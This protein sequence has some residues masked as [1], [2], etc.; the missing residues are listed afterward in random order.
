[1][2]NFDT[3][4]CVRCESRNVALIGP[5]PPN[6]LIKKYAKI[7]EVALPLIGI[8]SPNGSIDHSHSLSKFLTR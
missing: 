3:S 7:L 5:I 2:L 8:I 1:M 6:P 4:L